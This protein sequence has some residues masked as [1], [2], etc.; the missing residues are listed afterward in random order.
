M[1]STDELLDVLRVIY[2]LLYETEENLGFALQVTLAF[3]LKIT[4]SVVFQLI[5]SSS[6]TVLR[7]GNKSSA[8]S[9]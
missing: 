9:G 7:R 8:F 2:Y 6:T 3:I 1:V 5:V 4:F